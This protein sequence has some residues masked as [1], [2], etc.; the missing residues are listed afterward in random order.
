MIKTILI[1]GIA[2]LMLASQKNCSNKNMPAGCYKGRLEIKAICSNYTIK[3]LEGNVDTTRVAGNWTDETTS[4]RYSN[5][6]ALDN[7]CSFPDDLQQGDEFYF[8]IK[9]EKDTGCMVCKAY[10][11]VPPKRL[12][13]TVSKTACP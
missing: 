12:A 1:S 6:F 5:V 3:V 9:E 11:P 4:K 10:Y 2:A 7:P 8:T 13:I